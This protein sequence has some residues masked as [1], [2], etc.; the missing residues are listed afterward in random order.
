M[1]TLGSIVIVSAE[2]YR[3]GPPDNITRARRRVY[4]ILQRQ[5]S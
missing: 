3:K 4:S 1:N 5:A 2:S